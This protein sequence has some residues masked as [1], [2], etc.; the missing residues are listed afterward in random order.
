MHVCTQPQPRQQ[1]LVGHAGTARQSGLKTR[2]VDGGSSTSREADV[3]TLVPKDS[4][5]KPVDETRST[6]RFNRQGVNCS[7]C[8]ARCS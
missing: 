7:L 2:V 8:P 4:S 5:A 3:T 6:D 1:L